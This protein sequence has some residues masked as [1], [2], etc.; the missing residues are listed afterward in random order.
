MFR[1]LMSSRRFA[2]L[3]WCQ[4]F[5]AFNDNFVRNMLTMLILFRFGGEGASIKILLGT[6]VFVLPSIPLS[7]L[8]GEIA[9]SHDKARVARRLKFAEIGVQAI[10][11]AGFVFSS[12]PLLY[13]ALFGL[14]CVAALFGPIKYGILPDHL[15]REELVSGN[16]LV[17]GATF[18]AII[19]GLVVGGFAATEGRSA[20]SV[21]IQLMAFA[22]ACYGASRFIPPTGVGAPGLKVRRNVFASTGAV[23]RELHADD[24]QWVGGLATSWFWTVGALTLSLLPVI[25]KD[26]IGGGIEVEIATNLFFAVGIAAGSLGAAMLSH[27]RI[28]LAPAPLLLLVMAALAIDMGLLTYAMPTATH[29]VPLSEFFLSARGVRI[30]LEILVY[31]AAAG[32]FVVPIFAAVQAWAGEDRRA[33]V[34]GAVNAMNYIGMVAGSIVAMILLQLVGLSESMTFVVL[35]FANIVAAVYFFQRLPANPVAFFLRLLWRAAFRLEVRGIENLPPAHER[36]VIA[37]NHV[38]FLDAPIILSLMEKPPVFAID[39]GIA[40]R[41]WVKP[42]LRIADARPLDPARPFA[43]R[44]LAREVQAGKQLVIFPEGRITVTGG[45]MKI[46]DGAALIADRGEALITPVRLTGPERSFFSRLGAAKVGRRLFPKIVV[47]ILPPRRI[48][49]PETLRGRAR[50]RA[51]GAAL[52]DI[53]SDLVFETTD[54]RQTLHQAFEENARAMRGSQTVVQ[55]PLSGA[56]SARRFRIG[57]RVLA[58]R[59]AALSREGE[60][61]GLMLPNANGA[62][63]A[64]MAMQAAGR[65][66]AMLNYTAG[67]QN[68]VSAC[69][70]ARIG[71]VLTSRAFAEKGR[72]GPQIEA[73]GGV[74]R[75]IWL[76][77]LAANVSMADKLKAVL[78]A[79]RPLALR[80]PDDPAVVLFTSGS[81]GAPKG[82]ALSHTNLLANV[83]QLDARFDMTLADTMFNPLPVF[84]AFGLTGGLLLGLLRSM[85]VLLYPTP[86][87]YRQIPEVIY[88]Y[89]ATVLIGTDTFLAGYA[90]AANP[91]DFRSLR[92]VIAGAEPVKAETRKVYME[93][94]GLRILEGYGV[95]ECSPVV[96][97]NTAMFNKAGTT[98][99]L[100]PGI[101]PRLEPVPGIEDGARLHI[102]GPN[103]MLGYY[104]PDNPG[105]IEPLHGGWYD[106]GDVVAIDAEGFV[107]IRGRAKR[108]VKIAGEMVSLAAVEDLLTGLWPD[109][110]FAAL[111]APDPRKGERIVLATDKAGAA[112]AEV[113]A[114]LKAR[115]AADLM[116]PAAVVALAAMPLLGSGKT[117][118]VAL[119]RVMRE[120]L[121]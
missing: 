73:I 104:R 80:E 100:L 97:V 75:I 48:A 9:D 24:R 59:I 20:V 13:V 40:E 43:A 65:V 56:M 51:A 8:G 96:A 87:H 111:A 16:A 86:L 5:S 41:W 101:E 118:H 60:T 109:H 115:G 92:Y 82:V 12:L 74:A 112:R 102:R 61:I 98:G 23:I 66:P 18:G 95:T 25:V 69:G 58:T 55:D 27:G 49:V 39:H 7:A 89:D 57:V 21:V 10:A 31:S 84:H 70:T 67:A 44:A 36:G 85:R 117:D 15:R 45:L 46:Y 79:G 93:K 108:F 113:L 33:R 72:L 28:E 62:A 14:G 26:K 90:R 4:F 105:A 35:G 54:I 91:Y 64:F 50:R 81:E 53:M 32:L 29:E 11:A 103:V 22:L 34:V 2:P 3:F 107:A 68:L 38:S 106:T 42:F 30:A 6:L 94:F 76:E 1:T 99:K 121:S 83:A 114:W 119:A 78:A 17:E 110:K 47:S 71:L 77:D 19:L 37:I 52:Y 116:I 120:K 63:V 88:G